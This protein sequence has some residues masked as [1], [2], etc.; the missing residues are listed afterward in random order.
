MT[1]PA[2]K[3]ANQFVIPPG[4]EDAFREFF[5]SLD[6]DIQPGSPLEYELFLELANAAWTLYRCRKA[7]ASLAAFGIDPLLDD[8]CSE[9]LA[10]VDA[11]VQRCHTLIATIM[12]ELRGLQTERQYRVEVQPPDQF[13]DSAGTM[14]GAGALLDSARLAR[15]VLSTPLPPSGK[16]RQEED[17][18]RVLWGLNK[19]KPM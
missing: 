14:R 9:T 19:T 6:A 7:E 18:F 4:E 16:R 1:S 3:P 8:A 5:D 11:R 12:T 13:P 2:M 15:E 10:R 17:E